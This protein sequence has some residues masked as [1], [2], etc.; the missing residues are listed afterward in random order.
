MQKTFQKKKTCHKTACRIFLPLLSL[1][2]EIPSPATAKTSP[3]GRFAFR[4][5]GSIPLTIK[6]LDVKLHTIHFYLKCED[7]VVLHHS[8]AH[9]LH[10][11]SIKPVSAYS[12]SFVA[13]LP[14]PLLVDISENYGR[15]GQKKAREG[16]PTIGLRPCPLFTPLFLT[17]L[18]QKQYCYKLEGCILSLLVKI[19]YWVWVLLKQEL[20]L[21]LPT[22]GTFEMR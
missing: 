9:C 5:V 3:K 22:P 14:S 18:L 4:G 21:Q 10:H 16:G 20:L 8:Q 17:L 2:S 15:G 13:E 6:E 11:L 1:E 12:S 19:K 7:L